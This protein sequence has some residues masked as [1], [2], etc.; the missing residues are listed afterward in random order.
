MIIA[1]LDSGLLEVVSGILPAVILEYIGN[2]SLY[3]AIAVKPASWLL[4]SI[5]LQNST[6]FKEAFCHIAAL[7]PAWPWTDK[8]QTDLP[9]DLLSAIKSK[10][11]ELEHMRISVD[12]QL[13]MLTLQAPYLDAQNRP[14]L[15]IS[16][17]NHPYK[18]DVVNFWWHWV[19]RHLNHLDST[20]PI[21]AAAAHKASD[22]CNHINTSCLSRASFYRALAKGGDTYLPFNELVRKFK[23]AGRYLIGA[24]EEEMR[25]ALVE[26][27]GAAAGIVAPLV[28]SSLQLKGSGEL[29]YLSCV[30]VGEEEMVWKK[31]ETEEEDGEG[32]MEL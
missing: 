14:M 32:G 2:S 5:T 13:S 11:R 28:Q 20:E 23:V 26:L 30:A 16:E 4:L 22:F 7:Y 9:K 6:I 19:A 3:S 12:R 10:A 25:S 8:P 21:Q 24:D 17:I 1:K 31:E 18:Y 29:G 15:P 27:K